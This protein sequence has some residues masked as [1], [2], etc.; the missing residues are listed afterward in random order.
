MNEKPT[1]VTYVRDPQTRNQDTPYELKFD[2]WIK[3]MAEA[4]TTGVQFVMISHPW[5]IG[6]TYEEVMESLSRL[7]GSGLDLHIVQRNVKPADN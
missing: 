2:G 5:V 7:A 4:K 6:D 3:C 1:A